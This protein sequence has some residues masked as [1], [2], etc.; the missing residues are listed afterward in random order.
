MDLDWAQ[1]IA[2]I[3]ATLAAIAAI[4]MGYYQFKK[5][6]D[7]SDRIAHAS[8]KPLLG[9]YECAFEDHKA[10]NL[11][12]YGVGTAVI[13]SVQINRNGNQSVF[14][15]ADLFK[16]PYDL[17]WDDFW[18]FGKGT[19]FVQSGQEII[20]AEITKKKSH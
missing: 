3:A 14:K 20:L 2:A 10:V 8:I 18:V 4:G 6:Q 9:I 11:R 7:N 15:L 19:N 17:L 5:Q 13:T 1:T 16:F 12:N